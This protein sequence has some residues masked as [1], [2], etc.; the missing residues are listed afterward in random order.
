VLLAP[1]A[2]LNE[3]GSPVPQV[4]GEIEDMSTKTA[5]K[6]RLREYEIVYVLAPNADNAEAE[7]LNAKVTEVV[8]AFQGK[9]TKLDNWGRRKLAYPIKKHTR[10]VFVYTKYVAKPGVVAEI[11]RNLRIADSVLRYQSTLLR[12]MVDP[13]EVSVDPEDVKF[14]PLAPA[15]PE[16][17]L[18][19][20]QRLGL[21]PSAHRRQEVIE[22]D[23]VDPDLDDV[24]G[25][26]VATEGGVR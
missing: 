11:E 3:A 24:D 12:D 2:F 13:S 15:E 25:D 17:E 9:L 1:E 14:S 26:V 21:V 8:S 4:Q 16:E 19:F 23:A 6:D 20:E 18:S 10:A 22:D 7:R 5:T